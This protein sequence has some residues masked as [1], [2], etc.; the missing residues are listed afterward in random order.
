MGRGRAGRGARDRLAR[1]TC[2]EVRLPVYPAAKMTAALDTRTKSASALASHDSDGVVVEQFDP[3]LKWQLQA[4]ARLAVGVYDSNSEYKD[5]H[6]IRICCRH[7][8]FDQETK[9]DHPVQVRRSEKS[10]RAYFAGL[11]KCASVWVCPVCAPK[12]QAVRA[13]EVRT[14]I[15]KWTAQG[16]SVVLVTQTIPHSRQDRLEPLLERFTTALRKFKG[17]RGYERARKRF[18]ISGS[19]RALEVTHGGNGWHPHAHTILFLRQSPRPSHVHAALFPLW[20]SAAARA[21]FE[22]A[23]SPQAFDVQDASEVKNYVTKMGTEYQ[24]NAEHELVKAHSKRGRGSMTPFDMLRGLLDESKPELLARFA[25]YSACFEGRRQLVWSNGF[26]KELLGTDG[27]TDEQIAESIGEEDV[28]LAN[29]TPEQWILIRRHNLQGH[30]LKVV[31][32]FGSPG[33]RHLLSIYQL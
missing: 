33:L 22:Q 3:T 12:I 9:K 31:E 23:L 18:G 29:I 2:A 4:M 19:I 20:E 32:E 17:Q 11:M 21:G 8:L 6:R 5:G 28:V 16:G 14:A 26:K 10:N 13:Q 7:P 30:V 15:D 27:L 24:W 25:E 1:V